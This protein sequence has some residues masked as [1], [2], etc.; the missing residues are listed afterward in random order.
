MENL[1]VNNFINIFSFKRKYYGGPLI[2]FGVAWFLHSCQVFSVTLKDSM[3]SNIKWASC[4]YLSDLQALFFPTFVLF[5]LHQ[6]CYKILDEI[7]VKVE[8]ITRLLKFPFS[9]INY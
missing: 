5:C 2:V 7:E 6:V 3:T 4:L 8:I 9:L 1:I